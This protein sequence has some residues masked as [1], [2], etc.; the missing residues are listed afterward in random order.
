MGTVEYIECLLHITV[1]GEETSRL[2]PCIRSGDSCHTTSKE[3]FM[4]YASINDNPLHGSATRVLR[5]VGLYRLR[6]TEREE[7]NRSSDSRP[8]SHRE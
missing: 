4:S 1:S 2:R 3:M 5:S 7:N 8:L 6:H